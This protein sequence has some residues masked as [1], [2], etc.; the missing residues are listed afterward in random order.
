MNCN[1]YVKIRYHGRY[2]NKL[3]T[4]F[5]ARV[6]AEEHNLN[7]IDELDDIFFKIKEPI[8]YGNITNDN[9]NTYVIQDKDINNNKLP[10]YGKGIYI[11]DGYF[12][13]EDIFYENK[14]K[15]CSFIDLNYKKKDIFTLHIR[16]DDYFYPNSRN[17]NYNR[18]IIVSLDYYVDCIKKYAGNY[19]DIYIVCDKLRYKWEKKYMAE[20][21]S[22]IKLLNKN[23]IYK[24]NTINNDIISILQSNYIVTS[25]S[26]F[27]FWAVFFSKAEKIISFPYLGIDVLPNNKLKKW[28]NDPQIFKY[29]KNNRFIFNNNY[30]SNII[31]FFQKMY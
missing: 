30:S 21:I 20:L 18:N 24:V 5:I 17:K 2:G 11:F 1:G 14:D 13:F 19:K 7:L 3:F 27:C 29:N 16:L 28:N 15:I 8:N 10:Y 31:D 12:Q 23:P 26:T 6:Y 22:K 9:L 25:N 4:Y